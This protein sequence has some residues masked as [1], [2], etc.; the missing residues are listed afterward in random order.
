[1]GF[2]FGVC[3]RVQGHLR[4]GLCRGRLRIPQRHAAGAGT[5]VLH[6]GEVEGVGLK[7]SSTTSA[8]TAART[9]GSNSTSV[10][11]RDASTHSSAR[12]ATRA[13]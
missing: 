12:R 4:W 10:A 1:M 7:P 8:S 9:P 2:V 3:R 6:Q 5:P 13:S 11:W